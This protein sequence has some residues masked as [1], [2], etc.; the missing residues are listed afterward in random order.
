MKE[1]IEISKHELNDL[2]TNQ[3]SF[4]I[5]DIREKDEFNDFN[6]GGLNIPSHE[7]TDKI[8][9]LNTFENIVVLCSNGLRSHIM[10]RVI[11]KKI[12]S[13]QI[14]HLTEGII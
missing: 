8:D 13:A 4:I 7:I 10:S 11:Q 9:Y 1:I 5:V 14:Y 2:T 6:I 3:D 12:P